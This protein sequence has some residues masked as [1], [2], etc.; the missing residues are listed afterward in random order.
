[1][2]V[3]LYKSMEFTYLLQKKKNISIDDFDGYIQI[4]MFRK[5]GSNSK[6]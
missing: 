5:N 1:M 2:N 3:I 4:N 6:I